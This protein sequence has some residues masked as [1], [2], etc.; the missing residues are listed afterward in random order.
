MD[1]EAPDAG[2]VSRTEFCSSKKCVIIIGDAQEPMFESTIA[3]GFSLKQAMINACR[4]R[5]VGSHAVDLDQLLWEE[6][7]DLK[8]D[9]EPHLTHPSISDAWPLHECG[10]IVLVDKPRPLQLPSTYG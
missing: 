9:L 8:K 3:G 7:N 2:D 5:E 10:P 4:L 1:S 6:M